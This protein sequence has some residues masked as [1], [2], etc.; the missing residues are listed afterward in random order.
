MFRAFFDNTNFAVWVRNLVPHFEG[1]TWT[2][3][4]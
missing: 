1:G 3:G 4:F 2:E